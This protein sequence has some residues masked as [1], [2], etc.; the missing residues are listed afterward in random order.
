MKN[1]RGFIIFWFRCEKISKRIL[2][3]RLRVKNNWWF[4]LSKEN[5]C[6][7]FVY[8]MVVYHTLNRQCRDV[9]TWF[10]I[11]DRKNEVTIMSFTRSTVFDVSVILIFLSF[12]FSCSFD[13]SKMNKKFRCS[14]LKDILQEIKYGRYFF[15]KHSTLI[16]LTVEIAQLTFND[17]S[18]TML[19]KLAHHEWWSVMLQKLVGDM[20]IN[21]YIKT[22]CA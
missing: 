10:L 13:I 16:F 7:I 8:M 3:L 11:F 1:I 18:K 22:Y 5:Y 4:L 14:A 12:D 19:K 6:F 21:R 17:K 15:T 2:F 20:D 9:Q